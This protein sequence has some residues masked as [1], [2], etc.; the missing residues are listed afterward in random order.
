MAQLLQPVERPLGLGQ[1]N[2]LILRQIQ[3]VALA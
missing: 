3:G 2:E 1:R